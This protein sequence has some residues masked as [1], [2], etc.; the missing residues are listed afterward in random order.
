MRENHRFSPSRKIL[1]HSLFLRDVSLEN[2]PYRF[3]FCVAAMIMM[4]IYASICVTLVCNH[5]YIASI[6][7][8]YR[9]FT[10]GDNCLFLVEAKP[11]VCVGSV[12]YQRQWGKF[13]FIFLV[14]TYIPQC[15]HSVYLQIMKGV[16]KG[17]LRCKMSRHFKNIAGPC[18]FMLQWRRWKRASV[19]REWCLPWRYFLLRK[20]LIEMI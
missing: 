11:E 17:F 7:N 10:E 12:G 19:S 20:G 13:P 2:R 18:H 6:W 1:L 4:L 3:F 14:K 8:W 9:V 16:V 5:T 15:S